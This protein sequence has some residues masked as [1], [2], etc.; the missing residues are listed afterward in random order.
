MNKINFYIN[1]LSKA[2]FDYLNKHM[3]LLTIK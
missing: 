2:F 3:F 1:I